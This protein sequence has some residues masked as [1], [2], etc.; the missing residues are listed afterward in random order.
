MVY[1]R[2]Y[3]WPIDQIR[4]LKDLYLASNC[5]NMIQRNKGTIFHTNVSRLLSHIK[6]YFISLKYPSDT[7]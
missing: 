1:A 6:F 2:D 5:N 7:T 4:A 3:L